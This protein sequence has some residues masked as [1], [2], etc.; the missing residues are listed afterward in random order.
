MCAVVKSARIEDVRKAVIEYPDVYVVG[1]KPYA[2]GCYL[3]RK[4][5]GER[6][7]ELLLSCESNWRMLEILT[8][9]DTSID[10]LFGKKKNGPKGLFPQ[11]DSNPVSAKY[12][13]K[14]ALDY[15]TEG[16]E[17]INGLMGIPPLV[18]GVLQKIY[19]MWRGMK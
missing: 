1:N 9:N 13:L 11:Y 7:P 5:E 14:K 10:H 18:P 12:I 4:G 17:L 6:P 16:E 2:K 15:L 8:Q 19:K 3:F